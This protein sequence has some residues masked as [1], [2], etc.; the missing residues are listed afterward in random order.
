[1]AVY[2]Q[3]QGQIQ[4]VISIF[5][6]DITVTCL[7][8]YSF[9]CIWCGFTQCQNTFCLNCHD[10]SLVGYL[11]LGKVLEDFNLLPLQRI[12]LLYRDWIEANHVIGF[13]LTNFP[14][15]SFGNGHRTDETTQAR[16]IFGK[17]YGEVT[18]KVD[19]TNSIFTIM[20]IGWMQTRFAAIFTRPAWRRSG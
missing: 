8:I 1:Q 3:A 14:E 9:W 20:H 16:T 6:Q 5:Q 4:Y 19:C 18:G 15:F 13:Q 7:T 11:S 10:F 2:A 12:G 17:D